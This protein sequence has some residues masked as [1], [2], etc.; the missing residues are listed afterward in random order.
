MLRR[1]ARFEEARMQIVRSVQLALTYPVMVFG[2]VLLLV[3]GL[4]HFVF[5]QMLDMVSGPGRQL[6]MLTQALVAVSSV[7]SNPLLWGTAIAAVGFAVASG[8]LPRRELQAIWERV[9]MRNRFTRGL[10]CNMALASW[11][12]SL[13]MLV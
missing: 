1:L 3:I 5:A 2:L 7:L 11:T 9:A 6:P 4:G 12:Q 13:A 10:L 8:K